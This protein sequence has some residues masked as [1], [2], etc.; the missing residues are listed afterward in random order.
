[1]PVGAVLVHDG[2]II[3][4]GHNLVEAADDPTAHAEMLVIRQVT[5]SNATN[6]AQSLCRLPIQILL[7]L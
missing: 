4:E 1:M 2:E 3:A 7:Y 5:L 6:N